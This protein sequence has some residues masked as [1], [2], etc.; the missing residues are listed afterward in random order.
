M[1]GNNE[2]KNL[3][4]LSFI[5]S[6]DVFWVPAMCQHH[7]KLWVYKGPCSPRAYSLLG[8]VDLNELIAQMWNF[9]S[10]KHYK[11]AICGTERGIH[12]GRWSNEESQVWCPWEVCGSW[13]LK[14]E[15]RHK[16]ASS[17]R[18]PGQGPVRGR[19]TMGTG[20]KRRPV[21]AH[22]GWS[23]VPDLDGEAVS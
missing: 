16:E 4:I 3:F 9:N 5:H 17:R 20:M 21:G 1:A 23:M 8:E 2:D 7:A 22:V 15:E 6:P 13:D 19:G 12:R 10:D 18:T 14:N 11:E